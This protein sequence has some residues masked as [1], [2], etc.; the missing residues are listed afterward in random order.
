MRRDGRGGDERA[1]RTAAGEVERRA[2][3]RRG[4]GEGHA[5]IGRRAEGTEA[6]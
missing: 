2:G 4:T 5:A 1:A 6:G 3:G